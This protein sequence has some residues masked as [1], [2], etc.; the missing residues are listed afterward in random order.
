MR[1]PT[2]PNLSPSDPP[3]KR[4]RKLLVFL[5]L[6]FTAL[7]LLLFFRSPLSKVS[8]I[9]VE[10]NQLVQSEDITKASGIQ[11]ENQF[12]GVSSSEVEEKIKQ[13]KM[14]SSVKVSK[15]FPGSIVIQVEEYP[16]V[17]FQF[18]AD[19][20]T[21]F[22]LADGTAVSTQGLLSIVDKPFLTG[23]SQDDPSK[24]QLCKMLA[25]LSSNFLYEISE[26]KPFE[27][28]EAYPDKIKLY[29]RSGYEV[30]TTVS[31]FPD[32]MEY[33]SAY[34]QNLKENNLSSRRLTL[35]EVDSYADIDGSSKKDEQ[36]TNKTEDQA[37]DQVKDD[38][39]AKKGASSQP[40]TAT[41]KP[42][43]TAAKT[44]PTPSTTHKSG[45]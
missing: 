37:K 1:M 4:G 43:R 2:V 12:F 25:A 9:E 5:V 36:S 40:P 10:G 44:T 32:K 24:D 30:I 45:Q 28:T 8:K 34:I 41:P 38:K 31:Y 22:V 20:R 15:H 3:R 6:F 39:S 26:I 19:G 16:K 21:Q 11:I 33:L 29:T 18:G 35:L 17:A 23:F 27:Q 13:M 14:I 7:L 42:N